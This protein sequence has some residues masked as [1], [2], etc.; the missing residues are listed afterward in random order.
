[1]QQITVFKILWNGY[2]NYC[3][4]NES[5]YLR[6]GEHLLVPRVKKFKLHRSSDCS[7]VHKMFTACNLYPVVE[8]E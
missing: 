1:M 4:V 5:N 8:P 6:N 7:A 3:Q 2:F